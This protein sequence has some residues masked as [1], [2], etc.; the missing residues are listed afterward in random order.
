MSDLFDML[1][2]MPVDSRLVIRKDDKPSYF[3][4]IMLNDNTI[5]AATSDECTDPEDIVEKLRVS[6]NKTIKTM[7]QDWLDN[8]AAQRAQS[9]TK[10]DK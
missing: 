4:C 10:G 2:R 1:A 3:A 9:L 6:L 5:V 7:L 8:K